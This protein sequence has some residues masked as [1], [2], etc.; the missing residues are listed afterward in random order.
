MRLLSYF[1]HY[2]SF[3]T[4][5]WHL[6]GIFRTKTW[7][8]SKEILDMAYYPLAKITFTAVTVYLLMNLKK[9]SILKWIDRLHPVYYLFKNL[10]WTITY[11][12]LFNKCLKWSIPKLQQR[13][14]KYTVHPPL[15]NGFPEHNRNSPAGCKISLLCIQKQLCSFRIPFEIT[16]GFFSYL[17]FFY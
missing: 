5:L 1:E 11:F 14:P 9:T 16:A 2:Y 7:K 3:E 15:E 10:A 6:T 13:E 12:F 8:H 4:V 17:F